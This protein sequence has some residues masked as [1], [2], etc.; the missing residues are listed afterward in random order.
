MAEQ[1]LLRLDTELSRGAPIDAIPLAS[2][3]CFE[4]VDAHPF[5]D[6]N[7][8]VA[9]A[10]ATWLL[11]RTGYR[12]ICDLRQ[13]CRD[14][15][16]AQYEALAIRQGLHSGTADALPWRAFFTSMVENCFRAPSL[17]PQSVSEPTI[18]TK[19]GLG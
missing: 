3:V 7:S 5:V 17:L 11:E 10:V 18:R 13:Y 14:R 4:L 1:T 12:P 15:N 8:R 9:R 6:G 16:V 2:E 19:A